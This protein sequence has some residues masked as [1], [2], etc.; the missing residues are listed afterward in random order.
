MERGFLTM[1]D[2]NDPKK[3]GDFEQETEGTEA[4]GAGE[5]GLTTE[6]RHGG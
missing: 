5:K 6:R 4:E 3:G 1:N 2:P